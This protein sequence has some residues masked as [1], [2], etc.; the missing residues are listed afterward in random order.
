MKNKILALVFLIG[1]V[2]SGCATTNSP[3]IS[4]KDEK[5]VALW[6]VEKQNEPTSYL[7]GT[8]E[9][10]YDDKKLSKCLST[11]LSKSQKLLTEVLAPVDE[12]EMLNRDSIMF[13]LATVNSHN[14]NQLKS[15]LGTELY[16]E[17]KKFFEKYREEA[18]PFYDNLYGWASALVLYNSLVP[19]NTSSDNGIHTLLSKQAKENGI[20][21][22][23]LESY[24]VFGNILEN[25]PKDKIIQAIRLGLEFEKE[26][27]LDSKKLINAYNNGDIA[28][29]EALV[30]DEKEVLKYIPKKDYD[31]WKNWFY[32]TLLDDRTA[33]WV[34]KLLKQFKKEPTMIAV[35]LAHLFGENGLI[36]VLQKNGYKVTPIKN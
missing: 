4:Q 2:F 30:F 7:V 26:M 11:A 29:I 14:N 33:T 19:D 31:F 21:R 8:I 22:A 35:G 5:C 27:T 23:A 17:L 6:Q 9:A 20:K 34:P 13:F 28:A 18:L 12:N 15:E 1:I 32:K 36:N 24:T 10:N 16:A 25:L 3:T